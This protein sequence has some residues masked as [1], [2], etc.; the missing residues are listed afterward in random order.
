M[1]ASAPKDNKKGFLKYVNSKGRI[2]DNIGPLL[3]EVSH[4]TNKDV[5]KAEMFNAFFT[6]VYNMD[7]GLCEPWG[8]VLEYCTRGMINS[9]SSLKLCKTCC[10]TWLYIHAWGLIELIS[11]Y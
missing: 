9:Q 4:F 10:S 11:G 1:L 8:P 3:D 6:T 2:R 5:D 7:Y